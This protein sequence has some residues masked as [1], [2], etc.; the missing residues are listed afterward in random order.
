[1][2][3]PA[4]AEVI[5][6][7]V[8][9]AA[10]FISAERQ[11]RFQERMSSTAHQREVADLRKAGLNPILSA[12]G[13]GA[14]APA[15]A[16]FTPENPLRGYASNVVQAKLA[17]EQQRNLAQDT[18]LKMMQGFASNATTQ[19]ELS[20][21][22]LNKEALNK[23]AADIAAA[24]AAA[25]ASNAQAALLGANKQAVI[26]DNEGRRRE[27]EF[28]RSPAG[29]PYKYIEKGAPILDKLNPLNWLRHFGKKSIPIKPKGGR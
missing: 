16:M 14:S 18:L 8:S 3:T 4:M 20:Q 13:S 27:A 29:G 10:G 17:K 24:N 1:M 11:M 21:T 28:W 7:G 15:G 12:G 23:M 19:R 26:Y 25:N 6:S 2:L 22:A 9:S 5:G